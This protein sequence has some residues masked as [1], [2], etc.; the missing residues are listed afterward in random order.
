MPVVPK[1]RIASPCSANWDLMA[2]DS[3]VRYCSQCKL[4]VYNFSEMTS[5]EIQQL[6]AERTGRL[7]GRFYQRADG[8]IL[9]KNCPVGFRAAILRTSRAAAAA[10]TALVSIGPAIARPRPSQQSIPQT[11]Q[12]E[13]SFTVEVTD[14]TG[15]AMA[16]ATVTLVNKRTADRLISSTGSD[17]KTR[18]SA[19][20][21]DF[22][23]LSAT[24]AGFT[25]TMRKHIDISTGRITVR[26]EIGALMGEVVMVIPT[27]NAPLPDWASSNS[28]NS[29]SPSNAPDLATLLRRLVSR[30]RHL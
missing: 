19:S 6:I 5:G 4:N 7:C 15:A 21:A 28:L 10:L 11:Q 20:V 8:R 23:D 26:L 24:A 14:S 22:Y 27:T 30:V 12:A 25:T 3:R 29:P 2:G 17:G 1:L 13:Q 16:N 18:L 9:T